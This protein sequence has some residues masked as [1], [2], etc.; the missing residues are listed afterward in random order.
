MNSLE[1]EQTRPDVISPHDARRFFEDGA[2]R[3]RKPHKKMIDPKRDADSMD[4]RGV[5]AA[6]TVT[7]TLPHIY[8]AEGKRL[9]DDSEKFK[10]HYDLGLTA[11]RNAGILPLDERFVA[12]YTR[13]AEA[14]VNEAAGLPQ[15]RVNAPRRATPQ[16]AS[17]ELVHSAE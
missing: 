9:P 5:R 6:F 14:V 8:D 2:R 7:E 3:W 1:T 11:I 13:W 4:F 15:Q 16:A 10:E 12:G 17:A